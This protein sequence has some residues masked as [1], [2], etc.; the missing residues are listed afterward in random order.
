MQT[1]RITSEFDVE[2]QLGA[3]WFRTAIELLSTR[4]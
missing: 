4:V 2:L 3:N 1:A